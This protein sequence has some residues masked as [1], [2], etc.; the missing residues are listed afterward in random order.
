MA[1][2]D[3]GGMP[4]GGVGAGIGALGLGAD[5]YAFYENQKRQQSLQKIY[6]ILY[7]PNKLAAYAGKLMP[8]YS[9][10]AMQQFNR[11]VN[12]NWASATG[13]APGGASVRN[14]ADAW[15]AQTSS[16]WY[17]ALAGAEGSLRGASGAATSQPQQPLGALTN[18]MQLLFKLKGSQQTPTPSGIATLPNASGGQYNAGSPSLESPPLLGAESPIY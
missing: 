4:Y 5:A 6:D 11:G 17:K 8:Q 16:D 3:W 7:N 13:G 1:D 14:T 2:W 12:A 10:L 9:P 18:I 15:A